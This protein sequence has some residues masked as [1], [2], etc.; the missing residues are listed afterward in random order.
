[1]GGWKQLAY[2]GDLHE[3]E[4]TRHG[5]TIAMAIDPRVGDGMFEKDEDPWDALGAG[6]VHEHCPLAQ[7]GPMSLQG[8]VE[9]SLK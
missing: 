3:L 8:D 2:L 1:M 4:A 7:E 9:D 5:A 6:S